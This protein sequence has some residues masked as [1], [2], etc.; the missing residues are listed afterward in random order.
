MSPTLRAAGCPLALGTEAVSASMQVSCAKHQMGPSGAPAVPPRLLSH[1]QPLWS[2]A[3]MEASLTPLY[4]QGLV[5]DPNSP[6]HPDLASASV[7]AQPQR[8]RS[9]A[10]STSKVSGLLT[11]PAPLPASLPLS[12]AKAVLM[13]L[14]SYWAGR[15]IAP[16]SLGRQPGRKQGPVVFFSLIFSCIAFEAPV[17]APGQCSAAPSTQRL[18]RTASWGPVPASAGLV[19]VCSAK[20]CTVS[21]AQQAL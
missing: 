9:L 20:V 7:W 4:P 18:G 1:P 8:I 19:S 5:Y 12:P 11:L 13:Q 15:S 16:L 10:T 2:L 21:H 14:P 6:L 3:S 17:G